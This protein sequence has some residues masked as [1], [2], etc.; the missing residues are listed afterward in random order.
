[1]TPGTSGF[2]REDALH[3][4]LTQPSDLAGPLHLSLWRLHRESNPDLKF[5]KPPFYPLNYG[6]D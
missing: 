2:G 6:A 3:G 1:M 4:L 5:R